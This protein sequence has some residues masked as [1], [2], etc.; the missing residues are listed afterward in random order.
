[1]GGGLLN[2][3][4]Y[5]NQNIILNDNPTKTFFKAVY[6]KYTN[7]GMQKIRIDYNGLKSLHLTEPQLFTFKI[8]RYSE[9]L[10]NAYLSIDIPDIWSPIV[11]PK[12]CD[13]K[14]RPYE[15]RWIENLGFQMIKEITIECGGQ[16]IQKYSGSYI[17]AMVERDFTKDKKQLVDVMIGNTKEFTDPANSGTRNNQ[18]P[19]AFYSESTAGAE[20]SIRGRTIYVPINSWF[21][22][23]SR[24]AFPLISLQY[25][26]LVI[27]VT[28][29]PINELF[30]IRDIYNINA[31]HPYIKPNF[32]QSEFQFHRFLQTPPDVDL[33]YTDLATENSSGYNIHLLATYCFL[34]DEETKIF[35]CKE[36]YYLFKAVYEHTHPN[37]TGSRRVDLDTQ[38]LVSSWMFR[39]QRS[40]IS[41]RNEWSNY[42]NWGYNTVLPSD[43]S[44]PP[45]WGSVDFSCNNGCNCIEA[46]GPGRNPDG[47]LTNIMI[48]GDFAVKNAKHI[49]KSLGILFNGEFREN[50]QNY[51]VYNTVEKYLNTKGNAPDG[52]YCYNFSLNTDPFSIQPSGAVNLSKF[53]KIELEF[54]TQEPPMNSEAQFLT[55]C[56]PETGEVIGVNKPTINLYEFNY[57]LTVF[58]ERYNVLSFIGGNC[59]LMFTR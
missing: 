7:F 53:S 9:L 34:S 28:M 20:P 4:A 17:Q 56:D 24:M 54:T 57:D 45:E 43:I 18:Y 11:S 27:N 5:G 50:V 38:G 13:D 44:K 40:D 49:L 48:T 35:S 23:N 26:E 33:N 42:T 47:T 31:G 3:I 8:P 37:I 51:G 59:G 58:E 55:I 2:L 10:M 1:M 46:V 21:S 39:F 19:N 29:R 22:L 30:R 52:L 14:W 32:N 15:F 25:N 16:I 41:H 36:Q 12:N 6:A